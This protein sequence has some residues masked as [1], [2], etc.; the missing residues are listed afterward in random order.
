MRD[1]RNLELSFL[2]CLNNNGFFGGKFIFLGGNSVTL[3]VGA[4]RGD[5]GGDHAGRGALSDRGGGDGGGG[6]R[7]RVARG[8]R[9]G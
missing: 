1:S 3:Q 9:R 5:A 8:K 6:W 4:V 2:T 7:E